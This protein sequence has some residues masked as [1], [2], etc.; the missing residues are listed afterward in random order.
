[1]KLRKLAEGEHKNKQRRREDEWRREREK[2]KKITSNPIMYC[3]F[4]LPLFFGSN[5]AFDF[6][7]LSFVFSFYILFIFSLCFFSVRLLF[8]LFICC[9]FNFLYFRC[10]SS[11]ARI[12]FSCAFSVGLEILLILLWNIVLR[13]Y[14]SFPLR[15]SCSCTCK[16]QWKIMN[17]DRGKNILHIH[18]RSRRWGQHILF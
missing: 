18:Y 1:M 8:Y 15:S 9:S 13:Y 5:W 7:S 3:A 14:L 17:F 6:C 11:F 10:F 12:Y 4:W 16:T 2:K